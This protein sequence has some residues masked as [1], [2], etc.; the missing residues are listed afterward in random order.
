M[1][2]ERRHELQTN[3]LAD[4]LGEKIETAKPYSRAITGSAIAVVVVIFTIV[5]ISNQK[6]TALTRGW[7]EFDE[8]FTTRSIEGLRN[9]AEQYANTNVGLRALQA[10]ADIYLEKGTQLLF[11]SRDEAE[12]ELGKAISNYRTVADNAKQP[13]L[14]RRA[15][16]GLAQTYE[17]QNDLENAAKNYEHLTK[18]WPESALGKR[19]ERDLARIGKR[20]TEDF[21]AWFFKQN[22]SARPAPGTA[23]PGLGSRPDRPAGGF[24]DGA[25]ELPDQPDPS[26]E[27]GLTLPGEVPA[28]DGN[29]VEGIESL[30][31]DSAEETL[32]VETTPTEEP[33]SSTGDEPD[34]SDP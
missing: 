12:S 4:W 15:L 7:L 16:Y 25:F 2:T 19:A 20:S 13:M 18:L 26:V 23:Q 5:Y 6:S 9:V 29:T 17:A 34:G 33:A 22:P 1:K 32:P 11:V 28:G 14:K 31:N 10:A 3:T 21:Y 24:G 27:E 8:A 30:L